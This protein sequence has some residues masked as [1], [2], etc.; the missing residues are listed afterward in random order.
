VRHLVLASFEIVCPF[1]DRKA[2]SFSKLIG[3]GISEPKWMLVFDQN[4]T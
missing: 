1:F 3:L 2:W 4:L